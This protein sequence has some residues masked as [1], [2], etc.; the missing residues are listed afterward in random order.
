MK[1]IHAGSDELNFA[2]SPKV[3]ETV[4]ELDLGL[5]NRYD[6]DPKLLEKLS[7][8]Y[9]VS[10]SQIFL[11]QGIIGIIHRVFESALNK[12]DRVLIPELG[13]PYYQKISKKRELTVDTFTFKREGN[14]FCYDIKDLLAKLKKKPKVLVLID[15]ESPLGFSTPQKTIELILRKAPSQTLVILDQ[16]HEGF[17]D[18]EL[19]VGMLAR[20]YPNLLIARGLSKFYGLAG[21][22]IS[23]ALCGANVL[24]KM[25]FFEKY[26]GFNNMAQ[27]IAI[28]ALESKEHYKENV[29]QI[30][31]EKERFTE[32][33]N[34]L[35][36]YQ[37]MN[38][39]HM[40]CIV[41]VPKEHIST[42][43]EYFADQNILVRN[44]RDYWEKLSGF[45]KVSMCKPDE[46]DR[47]IDTFD[48]VSWLYE[49]RIENTDAE[50]Y[51]GKRE[52]GYMVH[53]KEISCKKSRL[54]MGVHRVIIPPG[55]F[56]PT[57]THLDQDELFEFHSDAIFELNGRR[58]N[59][60]SG[61]WIT[62]HPG[63]EHYIEALPHKFARFIPLRF[64]YGPEKP[65][66]E[67]NPEE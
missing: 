3:V 48:S 45:V 65:Q 27:K 22:R 35:S 47:I 56:L 53:R 51:L 39:D 6:R 54:L 34:K 30:R 11:E 63:D 15:P 40:A 16:A 20:T 66:G 7:E 64:P 12:N 9:G 18:Y 58:F 14:S 19:D 52:A 38:T 26:L 57:H 44:L 25:N 41:R 1:K 32:R 67:Y 23:Y 5:M 42:L 62:I 21:L 8:L 17:R 59:V 49:L 13:Y 4:R 50:T 36:G 2:P 29:R 60:K 33:I 10:K 37:V 55:K 28:A 24:S 46:M 61:D 31:V 43:T